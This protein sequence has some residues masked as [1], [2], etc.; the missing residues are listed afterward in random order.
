MQS[1]STIPF[2]WFALESL[3]HYCFSSQSDVWSFGIVMW[4]MFSFGKTP[5]LNGIVRELTWSCKRVQFTSSHSFLGQNSYWQ[6][7]QFVAGEISP[8]WEVS[9]AW[10][11]PYQGENYTTAFVLEGLKNY[12]IFFYFFV[13]V[14]NDIMMK[15]WHENPDKRPTFLQ[16]M[17]YI[18]TAELAVTWKSPYYLCWV[19]SIESGTHLVFELF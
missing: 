1:L 19:Q 18:K 14:Y 13:Q 2:K 11:L 10:G 17:D 8:G 3:K 6:R 7:K 5:Y 16:L 9:Y 12:Q 15:C 4:E